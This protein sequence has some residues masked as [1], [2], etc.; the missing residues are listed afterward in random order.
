MLAAYARVRKVPTF[1]IGD[2]MRSS[3]A[4]FDNKYVMP[5]LLP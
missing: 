3:V 5:V 2:L 1:D 4:P